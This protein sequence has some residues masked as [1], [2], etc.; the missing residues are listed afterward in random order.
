MVADYTGLLDA[1]LRGK[2]HD[3]FCE[4]T[5]VSSDDILASK[6]VVVGLPVAAYHEVGRY[7]VQNE[8]ILAACGIS[9]RTEESYR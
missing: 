1:F 6:I 4:T 3:I 5:T 9:I 2:I 8:A 7:A